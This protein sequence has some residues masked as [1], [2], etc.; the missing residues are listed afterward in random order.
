MR[1]AVRTVVV[2][3]TPSL[4]ESILGG[5]HLV[6]ESSR[7][8]GAVVRERNGRSSLQAGQEA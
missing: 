8:R 2:L 6:L 5:G 1:F 3:R 7:P 4:G